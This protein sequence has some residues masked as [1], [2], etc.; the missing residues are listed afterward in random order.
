M[1]AC[2]YSR[3]VKRKK[4]NPSGEK[5]PRKKN[6]SCRVFFFIKNFNQKVKISRLIL[7]HKTSCLHTNHPYLRED[8]YVSITL[9]THKRYRKWGSFLV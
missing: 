7:Q 6:L 2:T 9:A 8:I 5:P 1:S 4:I 3:H